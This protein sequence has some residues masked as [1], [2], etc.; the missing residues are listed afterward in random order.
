MATEDRAAARAVSLALALKQAP[1]SFDFF[2]AVRHLECVHRD[3][4]R[5]GCSLRPM[6]DP[7]RLCQEPSLSFAPA[8]LASYYPG[9]NGRPPR[10]AGYFFGLLG[11]NGPLPAHLTEFIYY[12]VRNAR[13]TTFAHFLDV[14]HHRMMSLFYRAWANVRPTVSFDRPESDE[15]GVYL[16]SLFG[17]GMP[18][19]RDRDALPDIVKLH[20]AGRLVCQTHHPEGLRAMIEHFFKLSAVI[21]EFVGAWMRLPENGICRLG[22]DPATGTL[23]MTAIAGARIWGRGQKFR[24][25]LGPMGLT[26]YRRFLP[27]RDSL[28]R[29]VALVRGYVGDELN[30]D[31]NLVL[32]RDEVPALNLGESGYL[33]WTTWLGTRDLDRDADDLMLNP[34]AYVR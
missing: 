32:K 15:F 14:F 20:F 34:L 26:T 25:I 12:R 16:A 22:E 2:Q 28:R 27:G 29:L 24:I 4:P 10:L 1:Y 7:V 19:L 9:K 13:D 21:E 18:T 17:L 5:I 3:K 6:D 33:G 30:W 23:G 8:T 11:P 31:V